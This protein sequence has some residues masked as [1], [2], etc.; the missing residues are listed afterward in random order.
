M[1]H[2]AGDN[3]PRGPVRQDGPDAAVAPET[4]AARRQGS[5]VPIHGWALPLALAP[6]ALLL[7]IFALRLLVLSAGAFTA[8]LEG[9]NAGGV[10]NLIGLGWLGS[11]VVLSGSPIAATALTLLDAGVLS[12]LEAF[13]QLV[14]SRI[15][16]SFVVL[17]V[18]FIYYLRGQRLPD[19]V[20]V[21]VVAFL[22][23]ISTWIPVALLGAAALEWGWFDGL[24]IGA[25]APILTL[26]TDVFDP[27]LEPIQ[28]ELPDGLLF[29]AGL[30]LLLAALR[31]FDAVLPTAEATS[32]RLA[33]LPG[34][35]QTRWALFLLGALVTLVTLSVAV[36]LTLL[37]PL[38]L[39]GAIRR[40][41]IIP[42]VLGAN[43]TTFADTLFAAATLENGATG[44]VVLTTIVL[45]L[46]VALVVLA[47]LYR[48]YVAGIG[49]AARAI[50]RDRRSLAWFVGAIVAAPVVL[51][52]L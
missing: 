16:A 14:G 43:I 8:I 23:T 20:Y 5:A 39:R 51:L 6:V 17:A 45:A 38:A 48:P 35:L 24:E 31:L 3:P 34:A 44:T 29:F 18:G 33:H 36:S 37:V 32:G 2:L 21:G 41:A 52:L 49:W 1:G 19:S 50:S 30:F 12:E 13:A 11:Y 40:N 47:L 26:T 4:A 27:I 46:G 28:G 9:V 22:V 7:F 10:F 42:Y 25:V 15:G